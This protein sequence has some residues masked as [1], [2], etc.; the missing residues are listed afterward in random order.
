MESSNWRWRRWP[1]FS[2]GSTN[3]W[4]HIRRWWR[5]RWKPSWC[6]GRRR[7]RR[8]WRSS[9]VGSSSWGGIRSRTCWLTSHALLLGCVSLQLLLSI[10]I[11]CGCPRYGRHVKVIHLLLGRVPLVLHLLK[12]AFLEE[13]VERD[14]LDLALRVHL[15]LLVGFLL[16]FEG[17]L[18]GGL[19]LL[20]L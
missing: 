9:R 20:P 5:R 13:L 3:W 1:S 16:L 15:V 7:S 6:T 4:R 8:W 14:G 10:G 12:D 19:F 11:D 2:C 17:L 18:H